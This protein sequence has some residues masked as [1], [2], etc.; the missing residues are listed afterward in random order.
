MIDELLRIYEEMK[1]QE[2]ADLLECPVG[3]AKANFFHAMNNL[4]K[5]LA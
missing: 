2:I 3:T 5:A 4:R 1:F